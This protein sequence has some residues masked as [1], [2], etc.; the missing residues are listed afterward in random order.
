MSEEEANNNNNN[1]NAESRNVQQQPVTTLSD[2]E[3]QLIQD[4]ARVSGLNFTVDS[5][6]PE[7]AKAVQEKTIYEISVWIANE[8]QRLNLPALAAESAEISSLLSAFFTGKNVQQQPVVITTLS[9]AERQLIQDLARV[10]GLNFITVDSVPPEFAKAVQEKTI[11]EISV[12]IANERQ[13]LNL[14]ALKEGLAEIFHLLSAF[15]T[16]GGENSTGGGENRETW[17]TMSLQEEISQDAY[18]KN[19]NLLQGWIT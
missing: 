19:R 2:A 10:S 4:L 9:D 11:Y 6:P 18:Q 14:P 16:G 5:V 17:R 13:R 1:N 3:R 8:R 15:F 7:L 12:W